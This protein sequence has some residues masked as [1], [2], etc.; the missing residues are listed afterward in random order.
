MI[1][2]GGRSPTSAYGSVPSCRD[3][4]AAAFNKWILAHTQAYKGVLK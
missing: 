4:W 2:D 1:E 3:V